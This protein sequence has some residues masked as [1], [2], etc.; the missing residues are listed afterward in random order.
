MDV[1]QIDATIIW[2]LLLSILFGFALGFEREI[3]GKFAGLRTH[4][5]VC[6]GACVFTIISIYGFKFTTAEGVAGINDPARI[7]AQIITGIGFIG[8]GTV[9]RHGSNISGITTAATLWIV[10]AI[11]MAC[12]CG[13][14]IVAG[15][16]TLAS[17]IVLISIRH[18]ERR[19]LLSKF[20]SARQVSISFTCDSSHEEEVMKIIQENFKVINKLE[21]KI[22][23]GNRLLLKMS[24]NSQKP[25]F[26]IT[27]LFNKADNIKS[28]E[29]HEI[30]G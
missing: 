13:M 25:L 20:P 23:N 24:A 19:F 27:E 18:F 17:L 7:A 15:A 11:G 29:I 3:T 14:V 12:G 26:K 2:R 1:M 6:L 28:I 10:A 30:Q 5:L 21:K 22:E 8:A 9:M 4:I 16:S